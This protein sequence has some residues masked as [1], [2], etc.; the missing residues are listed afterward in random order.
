M[1][2]S[3]CNIKECISG[4][5]ASTSMRTPQKYMIVYSVMSSGTCFI[6]KFCQ[7]RRYITVYG[8]FTYMV[9][10]DCCMDASAILCS[11]QPLLYCGSHSTIF[12]NYHA[13]DTH[14]NAPNANNRQATS[15]SACHITKRCRLSLRR[16]V[17][18]IKTLQRRGY[19]ATTAD[20]S[21]DRTVKVR[22]LRHME[23]V[24][25]LSLIHI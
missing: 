14:L 18:I 25:A 20:H 3:I 2:L 1:C 24:C 12:Q 19:S 5:I 13:P 4:V 8:V 16:R 7:G 9:Y 22:I 10:L 17:H 15:T 21:C 23:S 11:H 6:K